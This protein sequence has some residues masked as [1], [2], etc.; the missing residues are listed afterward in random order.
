GVASAGKSLPLLFQ[1]S[2]LHQI[3]FQE[4]PKFFG[5]DTL[6]WYYPQIPITG[7]LFYVIALLAVGVAFWSLVR[8]PTLRNPEFLMLVLM[9]ACF[10]PYLMPAFRV[11]RFFL[12]GVFFFSSL[13]G[14]V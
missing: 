5:P 12:G 1:P 13:V 8:S 6:I 2:T 14:R 10:V 3:F 9:A 4:L 11:P 7:W